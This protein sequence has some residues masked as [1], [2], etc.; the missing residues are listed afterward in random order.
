VLE[1]IG[2][3]RAFLERVLGVPRAKSEI[4]AR[5]I[6]TNDLFIAR[7]HAAKLGLEIA[8]GS[9]AEGAPDRYADAL[10]R[11][12][13]VRLGPTRWAVDIDPSFYA[14][15]YLR[16]WQL[17]AL[18]F[19]T[20]RDRFDEDWFVNPRS[21]PFLQGLWALGQSKSA[22]EIATEVFGTPLDTD[23]LARRFE[24]RLG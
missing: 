2:G 10:S 14:A 13:G 21:G 18:A 15:R 22:D 20:L 4:P 12:S 8:L 3:S 5:E 23:R 1:R 19:E 24:T 6:A 11:A 16:A 9:T 17:E 7:R